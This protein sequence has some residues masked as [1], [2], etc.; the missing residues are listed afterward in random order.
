MSDGQTYYSSNPWQM[1]H[2]SSPDPTYGNNGF[3]S[4]PTS[5]DGQSHVPGRLPASPA[6]TASN[7]S[8]HSVTEFNGLKSP[9]DVYRERGAGA[10]ALTLLGEAV[11]VA[12]QAT[13]PSRG[14]SL[15]QGLSARQMALLQYDI[16]AKEDKISRERMN[17]L[18][19]VHGMGKVAAV[20]RFGSEKQAESSRA[21]KVPTPD[22]VRDRETMSGMKYQ[23]H[24]DRERIARDKALRLLNGDFFGKEMIAFL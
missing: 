15:S 2:R 21:K 22:D 12:P 8:L 16:T 5:P 14:G 13:T 6:S 17:A 3:T 4:S 10:R 7:A 19:K 23:L 24:W 18:R 9:L 1:Q 11:G 20:K